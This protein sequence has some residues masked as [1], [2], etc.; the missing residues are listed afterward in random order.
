MFIRIVLVA[1]L[2]Q[3]FDRILVDKKL[4]VICVWPKKV[5]ILCGVFYSKNLNKSIFFFMGE[6]E[7][8]R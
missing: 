7:K 3:W 2:V 6:C 4:N 8:K 1:F 5:T